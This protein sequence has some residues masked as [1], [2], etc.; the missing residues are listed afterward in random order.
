MGKRTKLL[1]AKSDE[2]GGWLSSITSVKKVCDEIAECV[3][4]VVIQMGQDGWKWCI[5]TCGNDPEWS[6]KMS[7]A[8][9][10]NVSMRF[11]CVLQ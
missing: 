3:S 6:L 2:Q 5:T 10:N 1:G 11:K 8:L 7:I 4:Q 9:P